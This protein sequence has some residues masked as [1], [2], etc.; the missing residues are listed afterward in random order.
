MLIDYRANNAQQSSAPTT[1]I[2]SPHASSLLNSGR[3]SSAAAPRDAQRADR[4]ERR[5][6]DQMAADVHRRGDRERAGARR[7]AAASPGTIGRNAGSTTPDV[8]L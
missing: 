2:D 3:L 1:D 7:A 8:L 5:D 4:R 6:V